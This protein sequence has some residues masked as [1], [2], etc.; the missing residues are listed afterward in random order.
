MEDS[1]PDCEENNIKI[2]RLEKQ[3][4]EYE[5]KKVEIK[6]ETPGLTINALYGHK[7]KNIEALKMTK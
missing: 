7:S 2:K 3:L 5:L 6:K 4:V 1:A